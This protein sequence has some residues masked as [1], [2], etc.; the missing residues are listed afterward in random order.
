[1]LVTIF[2]VYLFYICIAY[3]GCSKKSLQ[4][5]RYITILSI[6]MHLK[7]YTFST[8]S[9]ELLLIQIVCDCLCSE[10]CTGTDNNNMD[11]YKCLIE[12][13]IMANEACNRFRTNYCLLQY[14]SRIIIVEQFIVHK[15]NIFNYQLHTRLDQTG[16]WCI[17]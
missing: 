17:M 11:F 1:M 10:H 7:C 15:L 3:V 8:Y 12:D 2:V 4:S 13:M 14:C 9:N 16:A 5:N 6:S